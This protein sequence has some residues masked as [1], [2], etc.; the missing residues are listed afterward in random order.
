MVRDTLGTL[1]RWWFIIVVV[2]ALMGG[3]TLALS[4]S[5]MFGG[6]VGIALGAMKEGFGALVD[7]WNLSSGGAL[8]EPLLPAEPTDP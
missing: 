8:G 2:G 5:N 1:V 4:W 3:A 7:G 6:T